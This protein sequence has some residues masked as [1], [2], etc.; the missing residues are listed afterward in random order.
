MGGDGYAGTYYA[1][2]TLIVGPPPRGATD[3]LGRQRFLQTSIL[4]Y[5][6]ESWKRLREGKW[7]RW[8]NV[9]VGSRVQVVYL[10]ACDG[11]KKAAAWQEHLAP[12]RVISY[13]RTSAVWDHAWWFA[14]VGPAQLERLK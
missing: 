6:R 13:N 9:P 10:F 7:D 5:N 8:E 11:G 12:A 1:P 4:P 14:F 2:E 3:E